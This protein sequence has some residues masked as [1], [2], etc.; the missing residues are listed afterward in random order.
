MDHK[1]QTVF[2][3]IALISILIPDL[4]EGTETCQGLFD[5]DNYLNFT[6]RLKEIANCSDDHVRSLEAE[7]QGELLQ[8]LTNAA[9]QLKSTRMKACRD[10]HPKNCSFP[11]IPRNGGLICLTHEKTRYC[12]PMCNQVGTHSVTHSTALFTFTFPHPHQL[13]APGESFSDARYQRPR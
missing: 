7:K 2:A 11:L 4:T 5:N 6:S 1:L 8:L 10:V 12:K 3:L 13:S 9:E